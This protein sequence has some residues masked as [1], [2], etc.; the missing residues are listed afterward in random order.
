MTFI[1]VEYHGVHTAGPE[2]FSCVLL[3]WAEQ[4]RVLPLWISP[5]TATEL[6]AR[7]AGY[8]PRRPSTHELLAETL[9]SMTA[10]VAAI[11]LI[12]AYEGTFIASLVLRDGEEIDARASDAV[13]LA[14]MLELDIHVDEDTLA[15]NSFYASDTDLRQYLGFSLGDHGKDDEDAVSASGDAQAD[16]DFSQ[17]MESLGFSESDLTRPGDA[18]DTDGDDPDGTDEG[19]ENR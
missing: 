19:R 18:E 8:S 10:G 5:I 11:N 14:R 3:R 9:N 4:N 17:L 15:Q 13:M 12:S 16:A 7:D 2:D 6:D 1:A